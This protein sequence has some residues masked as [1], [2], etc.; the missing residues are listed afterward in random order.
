MWPHSLVP[1]GD[2]AV[3]ID[4]SA[5]AGDATRDLIR[6]LDAHVRDACPAGVTAIVPAIQSLTLHYEPTLLTFVSLENYIRAT[7]ATLRIVPAPTRAPIE[8]PVC[9]GHDV[10]PDLDVVASTHRTST[11]A[12]IEAHTA[13]LYTVAMIGFLPGFPYLEGLATA[14][15][16]P[17]RAAPRTG[18]PAGSV[19]IGGQ[20]TGIYPCR[21]PGGWQLIGRTPRALFDPNRPSPSLLAPGDQIRF[22]AISA[23]ELHDTTEYA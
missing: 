3:T 5:V 8:I 17:R 19:G 2:R 15:H 11:A 6:C 13:G 18:V 14:L 21:S 9:Y 23:E 4:L 16:T 22:V 10:G 1:L 12:I 20:S 7:L